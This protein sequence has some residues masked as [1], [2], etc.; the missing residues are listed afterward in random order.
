MPHPPVW[1]VAP[2]MANLSLDRAHF[3]RFFD[4]APPSGL[5]GPF[6][7]SGPWP[8]EWP[9]GCSPGM[10]LLLEGGLAGES[11]GPRISVGGR[12]FHFYYGFIAEP[13]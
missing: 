11:S 8:Q 9:I 7:P 12:N 3:D 13:L 4:D 10:V 5:G 1:T 2:G 6:S